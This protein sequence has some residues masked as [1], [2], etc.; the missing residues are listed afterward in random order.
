[1]D[2]ITH[3]IEKLEKL[4]PIE[5]C[6]SQ[7]KY[8]K[9]NNIKSLVML[10]FTSLTASLFSQPAYVVKDMIN[11]SFIPAVYENKSFNGYLADRMKINLEK[12]LLQ[13]NL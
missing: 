9:M 10:G 6:R 3:R 1:M 11:D 8:K 13:I 4:I 12:R 2:R 7:T 5:N